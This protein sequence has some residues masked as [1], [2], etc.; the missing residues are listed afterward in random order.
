MDQSGEVDFGEFLQWYQN[1]VK[2]NALNPE[3]FYATFGVK[4]L[5]NAG[6]AAS[7]AKPAVDVEAIA[8]QGGLEKKPKG[9]KA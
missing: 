9:E 7:E 2:T 8:A 5:S 3:A 6:A 4:R 1:I